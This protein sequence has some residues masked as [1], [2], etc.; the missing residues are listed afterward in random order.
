MND[1]VSEW[2]YD[3]YS[4]QDN[5][6]FNEFNL[7]YRVYGEPEEVPRVVAGGSWKKA[8]NE[9]SKLNDTDQMIFHRM[10][11]PEDSASAT[12]GFRCAM[13]GTSEM[14]Y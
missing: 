1:G 14:K 7:R 9:L 8:G 5:V 13:S 4:S 12:I 11:A 2:T 10:S 6:N 3:S